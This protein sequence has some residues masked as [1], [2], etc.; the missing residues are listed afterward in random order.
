[1]LTAPFP[2]VFGFPLRGDK[3]FVPWLPMQPVWSVYTVSVEGIYCVSG[4]YIPLPCCLP[5]SLVRA[6]VRG[7]ERNTTRGE[8]INIEIPHYTEQKESY[9][10]NFTINTRVRRETV[11][12]NSQDSTGLSNNEGHQQ[13]WTCSGSW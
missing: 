6:A 10:Q 4:G 8:N 3:V 1:M 11:T 2:K 13:G 9:K 12:D 7:A 5:P